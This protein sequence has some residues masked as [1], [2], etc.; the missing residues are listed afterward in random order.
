MRRTAIMIISV[1]ILFQ[2][3]NCWETECRTKILKSIQEAI[4][5]EDISQASEDLVQTFKEKGTALKL[6]DSYLQ[7][8]SDNEDR[9]DKETSGEIF[10]SAETEFDKAYVSR[11]LK[12]NAV[13]PSTNKALVTYSFV[14]VCC[15]WMTPCITIKL[16]VL[17]KVD[18]PDADTD[19]NTI[20][21]SFAA[22]WQGRIESVINNRI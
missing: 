18:I 8:D 9:V 19:R 17:G 22:V 13:D 21:H 16:G 15:Y 5:K 4:R 6:Y 10:Q 14:G 20:S 12:V 3:S 7:Y 11:E 1:V 2:V